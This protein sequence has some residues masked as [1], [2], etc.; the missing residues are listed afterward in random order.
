MAYT[1]NYNLFVTDDA[2]T[3]FKTWREAMNATSNSN[4]T[5]ID[6]ALTTIA[7]TAGGKQAAITANGILK[8]D[9]NGTITA[10]TVDSE[11]TLNSANLVTSDGVATALSGKA[12]SS[13]T[14]ATSDVT[15]GSFSVSRG[16]TGRSTL[17]SGSYLVGNGTSSVSLKTAS[18][19]RTNIGACQ[20]TEYTGTFAANGWAADTYGYYAQTINITGLAETY[21]VSPQVGVVLT[22]TNKTDDAATLKGFSLIG[23]FDTG[24][25]TLT[26]QCIGAAPTVAVPVKVVVFS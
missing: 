17:T 5:K 16:G 20:V 6:A 19:V 11:P 8:G 26:A 7:T 2:S 18:E 9:G 21:S 4:M 23:I 25:G 12:A 24:S 14:H 1:T 10:A 22:G 3:T 15:S 13:H